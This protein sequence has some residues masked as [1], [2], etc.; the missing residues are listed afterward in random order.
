MAKVTIKDIAKKVGVSTTSVSFA[1]NDPDRLPGETVQRILE[2]AEELGYIP[3]PVARILKT[4]KT[5]TLGVLVPQPI[6]EIIRNP[7]FPELLEGIGEICTKV[8]LSLL[9]VPPLEGSMK[10]AIANAM[11]DGFIT[12]GLEPSK[13]IMVILGQRGVPYV[14]VDSDPIEGVGAVNIEDEKGAYKAMAYI[15]N[16]GHRHIAILA[17]RSGKHGKFQEYQ[18]T[19]RRRIMGYQS[20]L[21]KFNLSIDGEKVR[22]IECASTTRGGR[23]GFQRVWRFKHR[24]TAIVAMS[25]IIAIGAISCARDKEVQVPEELSIIGFDDVPM[26]NVACPALTT[27]HQPLREKGK[28]AAE[29]LIQHLEG[30]PDVRH[31]TLATRLVTRDSVGKPR[32]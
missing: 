29:I 22:L 5:G 24:P 13:Q 8:G 25:D 18:G 14:M 2:A 30:K 1:F 6:H 19:L 9:I 20:A 11:A 4:G 7:F 23:N 21:R 17:I 10:R 15:L 32:R 27:V 26:A 31:I 28:L 16:Q 3:D 12:L